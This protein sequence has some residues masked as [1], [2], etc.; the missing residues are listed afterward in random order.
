MEITLYPWGLI[1]DFV[2]T[3]TVW[4]RGE[5]REAA[6]SMYIKS[7]NQTDDYRFNPC[8]MWRVNVFRRSKGKH[9]L[10]L[11]YFHFEFMEMFFQKHPEIENK[12]PIIF[13]KLCDRSMKIFTTLAHFLIEVLGI[14][15]CWV[16][17]IDTSKPETKLNK[18]NNTILFFSLK[19]D[20][21]T[22][23][24]NHSFPSFY[25]SLILT[26]FLSFR[27]I[28]PLFFFLRKMKAFNWWQPDRT[29]QN[30]VILGKSS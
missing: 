21:S 14:F 13:P 5:I 18:S 19:I 28:P 2:W 24:L 1:Q 8:C 6:S 30:T 17:V 11:H 27:F 22:I 20:S 26:H 15:H 16:N 4:L 10:S 12:L 3:I 29:T 25:F 23:H 7:V 9:F